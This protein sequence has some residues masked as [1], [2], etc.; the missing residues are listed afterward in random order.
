[1]DKQ[2][3]SITMKWAFHF[4]V[5][6]KGSFPLDMLRYD[7]CF[8]YMGEDAGQIEYRPDEPRSS[9]TV[10]LVH[11]NSEAKWTPTGARWESFG[12]RVV[13]DRSRV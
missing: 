8:P 2:K 5:I 1:M 13:D 3:L 12:W 11:Y 10:N 6:G 7:S 9:R 4:R